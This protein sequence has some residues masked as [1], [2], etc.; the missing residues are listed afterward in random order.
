MFVMPDSDGYG[1]VVGRLRQ[2][3]LSVCRKGTELRLLSAICRWALVV[4]VVA[5]T[6]APTRGWLEEMAPQAMASRTPVDVE[7]LDPVRSTNYEFLA[8]DEFGAPHRWWPCN[9]ITWRHNI[10][11]DSILQAVRRAIFNA[12]SITGLVFVEQGPTHVVPGAEQ[13]TRI[14][15]TSIVIATIPRSELE[16]SDPPALNSRR[17]GK[18]IVKMATFGDEPLITAATILLADDIDDARWAETVTMHELGH[19]LGLDHS[20]DETQVMAP[21]ISSERAPR[22]GA[23]DLTGLLR[24]ARPPWGGCN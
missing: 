5:V 2:K 24:L 17:A 3:T 12:Q 15:G 13:L 10:A 23:G 8:V 9:D 16:N 11:D 20:D 6:A 4:G 19:A 18:A 7:A 1:R 21:L 14:E 22:W